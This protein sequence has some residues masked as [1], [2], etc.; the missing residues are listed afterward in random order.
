MLP[1]EIVIQA[2]N[3][4]FVALLYLFLFEV[5]RVA[6]R[7]LRSVATQQPVE[8][9]F[10]KLTVVQPG[11]T[12]VAPGTNFPLDPTTSIGRKLTNGIVLD[13]PTVSGEHAVLYLQD[14][15]WYLRDAG[16]T[17][18]TLVNGEDVVAPAPVQP[19][20]LL[21]LGGVQLRLSR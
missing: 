18:G 5:M 7:E 9:Q 17:N 20:D 15:S 6:L 21:T 10:G 4:G 3:V 19:G 13:D 14:D 8:S 11:N 16:S 12:G 1:F 2:L